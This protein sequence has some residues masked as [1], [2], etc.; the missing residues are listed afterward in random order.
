MTV[1]H[2][3]IPLYRRDS[4][5]FSAMLVFVAKHM[6]DLQGQI[7]PVT[8]AG[9]RGRALEIMGNR[10]QSVHTPPSDGTMLAAAIL[11]SIDVRHSV[12]FY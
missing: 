2:E 10:L 5:S 7:E 6:A 1:A 8:A 4:A 11:A 12:H 9:H 3:L